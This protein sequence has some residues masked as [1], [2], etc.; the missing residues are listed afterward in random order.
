MEK[1]FL[2]DTRYLIA[3]SEFVNK[4]K[5]SYRSAVLGLVFLE[6]IKKESHYDIVYTATD[7]HALLSLSHQSE[8][9][10]SELTPDVNGVVLSTYIRPVKQSMFEK[11][12]FLTG[13]RVE[14]HVSYLATKDG[15]FKTER[16]KHDDTFPNYR[17][18]LVDV[19]K[20]RAENVCRSFGIMAG[21]LNK[22]EAVGKAFKC[23][24]SC[25]LIPA[26]SP[27]ESIAVILHTTHANELEHRALI[28][29]V[30]L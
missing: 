29:P 18:V 5:N 25:E 10:F 6:V 11:S 24:Y 9:D 13:L 8:D 23:F 27:L 20:R 30:R 2:V 1:S 21:L 17:N 7:G 22:F 19:E 4:E 15:T 14:E 3:V 28:M 16:D 26:A 12:C